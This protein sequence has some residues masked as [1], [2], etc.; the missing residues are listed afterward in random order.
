MGA[1]QAT[2][3]RPPPPNPPERASEER[4]KL[5]RTITHTAHEVI[6]EQLRADLSKARAQA[7]RYKRWADDSLRDLDDAVEAL[8]VQSA[9]FKLYGGLALIGSATVA[10]MLGGIAGATF[11]KR[12]HSAMAA[13]LS[14]ELV[15][16]RRRGAAELAK[17]E[18]FG[19]GALAKS[20]IP[21]LDAMDRMCETG[22]GDEEGS[23]LTRAALH[24][25]LR[26]NGVVRIA[27]NV[28]DPFDVAVMEVRMW[29]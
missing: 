19:S 5:Q 15:D 8:D 6:T 21:A 24:D 29:P 20:L 7:S 11:A 9:Q 27:P 25:A 16:V 28:G 23:R 17:A 1:S 4:S 26:E 12:Q 10:A 3:A 22:G 14:Q 2:P 18:R 13:R